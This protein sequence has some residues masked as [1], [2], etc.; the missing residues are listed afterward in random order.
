ML[1]ALGLAAFVGGVGYPRYRR[2]RLIKT[3]L[4]TRADYPFGTTNRE[5]F[6]A[7]RQITGP[8]EPGK[9]DGFFWKADTACYGTRRYGAPLSFCHA[10]RVCAKGRDYV[11]VVLGSESWSIPGSSE[12]CLLL[13]DSR[14]A[15]LDE[16]GY[17][18]NTR[19]GTLDV[20]VTNGTANA[21][22][23]VVV[24]RKPGPWKPKPGVVATIRIEDGR[25]VEDKDVGEKADAPATE[26]PPNPPTGN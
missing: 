22:A 21:A 4:E 13:L 24:H 9:R 19:H 18:L 5:F 26:K 14:G 16:A 7:L 10:K 12:R 3:L 8:R 20:R 17:E 23:R 6:G 15:I 2:W 11:L 25:L 1:A